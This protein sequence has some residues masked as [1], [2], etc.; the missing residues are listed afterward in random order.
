M[1][2]WPDRCTIERVSGI[3]REDFERRFILSDEG[4][5]RPAILTDA[6]A[7][8]P[9]RA[10]WS[11][12]FFRERFGHLAVRVSAVNARREPSLVTAYE[13]TLAQYIDYIRAEDL[14]R[15]PAAGESVGERPDLPPDAGSLYW[16]ENLARREF[17]PLFDDFDVDLYFLDN[18]PARM[19]GEWKRFP[20]YLPYGNLFIGGAGS[21]VSLHRD[22]WST[23]T[24][25]SQ[26]EGRKQLMLFA[27]SAAPYL[28]T[29]DG[30][31]LDPRAVDE[32][33]FPDFGNATLH[34]GVLEPGE[35]LYMPP[36]WYHEIV[37]LGPS[38]SLAMNTFTVHNIGAYLPKLLA[39]PLMIFEALKNHPTMG[40][41]IREQTFRKSD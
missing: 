1:T 21:C 9:A 26:F 16:I 13:L 30:E 19:T 8:W 41:D 24:L 22:F 2:E 29:N 28:E 20:F 12:D 25:I 33:R 23:H 27:P 5:G 15:P 39:R 37:G 32:W 11:L 7:T 40:R 6:I 4:A 34:H 31:T 14:R 10:K 18:L 35:T 36:K 38:L 3:S 17:E